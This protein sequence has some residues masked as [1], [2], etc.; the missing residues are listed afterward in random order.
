M[1]T[2]PFTR[3]ETYQLYEPQLDGPLP[4]ILFLH[5]AGESGSDGVLPTTVGIGPAVVRE[6]ERFP[7]LIVFPQASRGYGWQGFNLDTAVAALDDV[8]K[9]FAIDED[10]VYVTGISMGGYGAWQLASM[11]PERFAAAVPICGGVRGSHERAAQR[12]ARMPQWIFHGDADDIIKVS[13]SRM[14]VAALRNAGAPIR[15]TEYAGVR[16]N[17]WDR[18]YAEPELLP[19]LLAQRLS[20][21]AS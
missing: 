14:M 11:H 13:E 10:R 7:A 15:Y 18:A 9:N 19:W 17:S 6:P 21:R 16:H 1:I 4:V 12:L 3:R 2:S 5:G 8:A 20:S